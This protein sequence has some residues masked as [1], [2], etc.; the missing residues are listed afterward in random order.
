MG[1]QSKSN[2]IIIVHRRCNEDCDITWDGCDWPSVK[3]RYYRLRPSY[4]LTHILDRDNGDNVPKGAIIGGA[5]GGAV[6]AIALA[7]LA[8]FLCRRR[9]RTTRPI[10]TQDSE[11]HVDM[12]PFDPYRDYDS[13]RSPMLTPPNA[14]YAR[15]G[16][17][18][19]ASWTAGG[20]PS[21]YGGI[22]VPRSVILSCTLYGSS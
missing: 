8:F 13:T 16:A 4:S 9:R 10:S 3:V 22:V 20:V 11:Y 6:V 1:R 5:A 2:C 12:T 19:E 18:S 17:M 15:P 21:E 14:G 7:L